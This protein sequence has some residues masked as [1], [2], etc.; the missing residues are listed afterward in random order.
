MKNLSIAFLAA[1][2]L[3][4][5]GA[6][7]KKGGGDAGEAMAKMSEFKD[8]MCACKD[9][10]CADKVTESYTKWGTD[11]AAKAGANKDMKP[12]PEMAKKMG[13]V[14]QAYTECATKAMMAGAGDMAGSGSA[15]VPTEGSAA[16]SAA[17]P[18]EGS[19]AGSAAP[20]A[21][22]AVETGIP[23]CDEYSAAI[24]KLATCDKLPEATRKQ[25]KDAFDQQA[26][27][28][29]SLPAES[30]AAAATG[31]KAAADALKQSGC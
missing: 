28:W 9:K 3:F 5:V 18:T 24:A 30:K 27:A 13:E 4:T 21:T 26:G 1:A 14:T 31:C 2:S 10:A 7:K 23:E 15:M 11:M 12:D 16:G 25:M 6:C 8:Q 17:V 19:A 20:A 29:K 22:G